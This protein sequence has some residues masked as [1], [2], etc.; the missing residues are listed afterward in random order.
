MVAYRK[1]AVCKAFW[2][3]AVSR[4]RS[5]TRWLFALGLTV[6]SGIQLGLCADLSIPAYVGGPGASVPVAVLF[7]N[8][9][10]PVSGLQ[11]DLSLDNSALSLSTVIG[12]A[13]RGSGKSLYAAPLAP[14]RTRFMIWELNQ[15]LV[16]D[17]A[18]V[19]LFVNVAPA[20]TVGV[21]NIH[22]E[23][24][25]ATDPDG[26]SVPVSTSDGTLTITPSYGAPVVPQGVL[27]G[28]SL[29][30]GAVAPGEII[31]IM[32]SAIGSV[33]TPEGITFDGFAAPVIYMSSDQVNAVVPF[34]IAGH[35]TTTL[36]I[37]N[38][39]GTAT[40]LS[41]P[42]VSS[43]P[44][45]FTLSGSGTGPG[46]ILNQDSTMN[47]PD[48]P[49]ERGSII[50]IYAT[51]AGQTD[52]PGIDGLISTKVLPKPLLPVSVQVGGAPAEI[53]YAVAAP[54][55]ISAVL[56]VNCR[57]P[58]QIAAGSSV[59]VLLSVGEATSP[60]VTVALK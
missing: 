1:V 42:V 12:S 58:V 30:P 19:N 32:G 18:V 31:A 44:G 16:L 33:P 28:A 34:G 38:S 8:D 20:A 52:P 4:L 56:Q 26:Q 50:V 57:V 10:R 21:Y 35:N 22:F 39:A 48:N 46:A 51:G 24:A 40:S 54:Y 3:P 13:A 49:A 55:E 43:T 45:I 41:L 37:L 15:N 14:N 25:V 36:D 29:L 7:A 5:A 2:H 11:F 9:G 17:G 23:A 47:S 6:Y 59:P 27:N 53:L 60:P